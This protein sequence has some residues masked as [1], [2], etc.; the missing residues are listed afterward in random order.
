[1]LPGPQC[2]H[3]SL[4]QSAVAARHADVQRAAVRRQHDL[5]GREGVAQVGGTERPAR[6]I[7]LELRRDR[8]V[9]VV[10]RHRDGCV[11]QVA[12]LVQ[13]AQDPA[14]VRIGVADRSH[15]VRAA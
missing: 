5:A 13:G 12:V 10:G 2:Y 15:T 3:H 1:M 9:A 11:R 8:H 14:Q 7:R 4:Q 6:P